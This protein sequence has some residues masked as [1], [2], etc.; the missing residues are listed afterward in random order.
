MDRGAFGRTN[1]HIFQFFQAF[2]GRCRHQATPRYSLSYTMP[3]PVLHHNPG[4]PAKIQVTG[5][6]KSG[7]RRNEPD[8]RRVR[9][10]SVRYFGAMAIPIG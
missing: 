8:R 4:E 7:R 6:Q 1:D 3:F 9:R 2:A 10:P 5:L